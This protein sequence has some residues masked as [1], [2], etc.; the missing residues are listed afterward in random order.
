MMQ[1]EWAGPNID[2]YLHKGKPWILLTSS[3][4]E[5]YSQDSPQ[6]NISSIKMVH[7]FPSSIARFSTFRCSFGDCSFGSHLGWGKRAKSEPKSEPAEWN[8]ENLW[9][10]DVCEETH[11]FLFFFFN[12]WFF[13]LCFLPI[14]FWNFQSVTTMVH[15][16]CG[17]TDG[18]NLFWRAFF[19]HGNPRRCT[20]SLPLATFPPT[21]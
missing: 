20:P 10:L 15:W 5:F 4:S 19:C 16:R 3:G 12:V 17:N 18:W 6:P 7:V 9:N 8:L 1:R 21:G 2:I 11:V 14:F 13:A